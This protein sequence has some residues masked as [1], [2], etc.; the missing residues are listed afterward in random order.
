MN[1]TAFI[2]DATYYTTHLHY[3]QNKIRNATK[4]IRYKCENK[5]IP[6]EN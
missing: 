4:P 1:A 2:L 5:K 3:I 6:N